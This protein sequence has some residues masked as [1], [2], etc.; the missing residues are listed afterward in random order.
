VRAVM[1]GELQPLWK[2]LAAAAGDS[3]ARAA[4]AELEKAKARAAEPPPPPSPPRSPAAS[5]GDECLGRGAQQSEKELG[6][7]LF[8]VHCGHLSKAV[9][10]LTQSPI[11]PIEERRVRRQLQRLQ[12]LAPIPPLPRLGGTEPFQSPSASLKAVLEHVPRARAAGPTG[13]S[14]ENYQ[15]MY[16]NGGADDLAIII[17][18]INAGAAHPA[19]YGILGDSRIIPL[20]KPDKG[21]RPIAI[22]DALARLAAKVICDANGSAFAEHFTTTRD[23]DA[24]AAAAAAGTAPPPA[25]LQLGVGVP[26]GT[27]LVVHIA[28]LL[29]EQNPAWACCS[30]DVKNGF[31]TIRRSA[32][33][34]AV[35]RGRFANLLPAVARSYCREGLLYTN[36][37]PLRGTVPRRHAARS[38]GEEEQLEAAATD[39]DDGGD[40]GGDEDSEPPVGSTDGVRQGDPL[41]PVL[42]AMGYHPA[43]V[44]VAAE[45]PDCIVL[46]YLDD[47]YVLGPPERAWAANCRL[48]E[49]MGE[50][51]GLMPNK[52]KIEFYAPDSSADLSFL[53]DYVRGSPS[54]ADPALR[55]LRGFKCV[56][57]YVG[58][59]DWAATQLASKLERALEVQL[60]KI[61][62]MHDT[63]RIAVSMQ[64]QLAL[65][66]YCSNTVPNY[67]LRTMPPRVVLRGLGDDGTRPS[68]AAAHDARIAA[69][70][71]S[72]FDFDTTSERGKRAARQMRLPTRMG[73][74]GLTE[75]ADIATSAYVGSLAANL[76]TIGALVP[77]LASIRPAAEPAAEAPHLPSITE[78]RAGLADLKAERDRLHSIQTRWE[79]NHV[80]HNVLGDP[81]YRFSPDDLP[82]AESL[83]TLEGMMLPRSRS[84]RASR[85]SNDEEDADVFSRAQRPLSTV[86]HHARWHSLRD[87]LAPSRREAVRFIS[88]SQPF[89]GAVYNAVPSRHD[90]RIASDEL[91]VMIQRRL[92]LPLS[93]LR[94]LDDYSTGLRRE[95]DELGDVFQTYHNHSRRHNSVAKILARAARQALATPV[96]VDS[97]A[98]EAYSAGARPDVT[99]WRGA[100]DRLHHRL[101]EVKVVCP[102][103]INEEATGEAGSYAGFANTSPALRRGIMGCESV[104]GRDPVAPHY[105]DALRKGHDVQPC[106]FE[107][108]GGFDEGAVKLLNEWGAR[109][110][111]KTPP[112][113]EPPW[114]ARN[115]VPYWSQIISKEA[116]RGAA[117]EILSRVREESAAREAARARGE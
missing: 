49:L 22:G 48:N 89:A 67:W 16:E 36:T 31:N 52:G 32:V 95:I 24:A 45:Y 25:P 115:Y 116:Q 42:F 55:R 83:P 87:D 90:T 81:T 40:D 113:E 88:A 41:G 10:A 54:N 58:D 27:E 29:L 108:F 78:L 2:Q 7:A 110:R 1:R 72:A 35:A 5:I 105:A 60:A 21:I 34:E 85:R 64:A 80:G 73:G 37:G 65:L 91:G 9:A 26:G 109:A 18:A 82:L 114:S 53:P 76:S 28:R 8:Y 93:A 107:I 20:E 59:D 47:T 44:K 75:A 97:L 94:G 46:G 62:R 96:H 56:G 92:G 19:F 12:P 30:N 38:E 77:P 102:I 71:A 106:I 79:V 43:L 17:G 98:H 101:L 63:N 104:G 112:G 6:R 68:A 13:L 74:L 23:A 57:A 33:L 66:R 103:S 84:K 70:A 69:A 111:G 86:R 3:L 11:A 100:P 51:C 39:D 99:I 14:F 4:D 61:G 15:A 50:L 117:A